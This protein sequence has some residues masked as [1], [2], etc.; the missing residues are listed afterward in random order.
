MIGQGQQ[1]A[2]VARPSH[3]LVVRSR[4]GRKRHGPARCE[5]EQQQRHVAVATIFQQRQ[6]RAVRAETRD[7]DDA[8]ALMDAGARAARQV[9][10]MDV[11]MCRVARIG[12]EGDA[13]P[14]RREGAPVMDHRRIVGQRARCRMFVR[15]IDQPKLLALVAAAIDAIDQPVIRRAAPQQRQLLVMG[16]QLPRGAGLQVQRPGL[17]QAGTTQVKQCP[18][19]EAEHRA[20]RGVDARIHLRLDRHASSPQE[21]VSI[22]APGRRPPPGL[23]TG[24]G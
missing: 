7:A 9:L 18:T 15:R 5:I 11:E 17:R 8:A 23:A 3:G 10:Q 16:G 13:R 21:P 20:S 22:A 4:P 19:V 2:S 12:G 14:V 24:H 1:R 6:H